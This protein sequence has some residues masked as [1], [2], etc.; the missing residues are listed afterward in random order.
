MIQVNFKERRTLQDFIMNGAKLKEKQLF[1]WWL[2]LVNVVFL[3]KLSVLLYQSFFL[4]TTFKST[5]Y[6]YVYIAYYLLIVIISV[7]N[8]FS[9]LASSIWGITKHLKIYTP[10]NLFKDIYNCFNCDKPGNNLLNQPYMKSKFL[11]NLY[12][13]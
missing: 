5:C 8:Y 12:F 9:L 4:A 7:V 1:N 10:F 3:F 13:S 2:L 6:A 11:V